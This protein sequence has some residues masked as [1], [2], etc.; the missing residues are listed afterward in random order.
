MPRRFQSCATWRFSSREPQASGPR[1]AWC[2][3]SPIRARPSMS[4]TIG[5]GRTDA[6]PPGPHLPFG[7]HVA[8][9]TRPSTPAELRRLSA[10]SAA[11]PRC[12][13]R[14]LGAACYFSVFASDH[15]SA[16][17]MS[18]QNACAASRRLDE[19]AGAE[20]GRHRRLEA[21]EH[22]SPA[23]R[24]ARGTS[25]AGAGSCA[26]RPGRPRSGTRPGPGSARR[27]GARR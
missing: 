3:A 6:V 16:A 8:V 26:R 22:L 27:W 13:R 7:V 1:R 25:H 24:N 18:S 10:C 4:T 20:V 23:A 5:R 12:R 14:G 21:V 11:T 19:H 9:D 15:T 17:G 2:A